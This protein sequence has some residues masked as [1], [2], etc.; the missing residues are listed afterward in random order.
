VAYDIVLEVALKA[1][2]TTEPSRA[3]LLEVV[4]DRI[5]IVLC[6]RVVPFIHCIMDCRQA[7]DVTGKLQTG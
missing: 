6:K 1:H 5:C 2:S 3:W 4:V 7:Q